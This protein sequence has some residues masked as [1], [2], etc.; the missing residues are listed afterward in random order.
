VRSVRSAATRISRSA[1]S[2]MRAFSRA[3]RACHAPPPSR[4]SRPFLV[5][6]ARQELDILDRQVELVAAGVFEREAFV[7]RAHGGDGLEPP[8]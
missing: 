7:R 6:V 2:R 1:I 8:V 5:A 4:S 3:L